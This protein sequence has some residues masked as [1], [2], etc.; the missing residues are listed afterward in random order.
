MAKYSLGQANTVGPSGVGTP[1]LRLVDARREVHG[2]HTQQK[3]AE[4]V[5]RRMAGGAARDGISDHEDHRPDEQ[6]TDNLAT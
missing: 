6:D 4:D 2:E 3:A 5:E 1:P